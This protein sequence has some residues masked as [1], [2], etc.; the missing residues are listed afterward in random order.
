MK[1]DP[2]LWVIDLTMPPLLF[3]SRHRVPQ[4]DFM[5]Y[6]GVVKRYLITG[7]NSNGSME[8]RLST[9]SIINRSL[10][11]Q[12]DRWSNLKIVTDSEYYFTWPKLED[13]RHPL[14]LLWQSPGIAFKTDLENSSYLLFWYAALGLHQCWYGFKKQWACTRCWTEISCGVYPSNAE[15]TF[16]CNTRMRRFKKKN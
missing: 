11:V 4:L 14:N 1:P 12:M 5:I 9:T 2:P 15:A 10:V 16:V 8:N 7:V 3:T 6:R 13:S